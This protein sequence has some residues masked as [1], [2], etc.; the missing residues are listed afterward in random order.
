MGQAPP[1]PDKTREDFFDH[2]WRFLWPHVFYF[3]PIWIWPAVAFL[4]FESLPVLAIAFGLVA[5]LVSGIPC[6]RGRLAW[7]PTVLL[8]ALLPFGIWAVMV[9]GSKLVEMVS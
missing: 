8:N 4:T 2:P 5:A 7:G 6:L 3:I 1:Q 9:F